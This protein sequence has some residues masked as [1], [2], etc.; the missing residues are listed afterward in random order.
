[1]LMSI[2]L[3]KPAILV[4]NYT[5]VTSLPLGTSVQVVQPFWSAYIESIV[6]SIVI[7]YL[8]VHDK[9][10]GLFLVIPSGRI[11]H[12]KQYWG[13]YSSKLYIIHRMHSVNA[14][15]YLAVISLF[16]MTGRDGAV[17]VNSSS[18][19]MGRVYFVPYAPESDVKKSAP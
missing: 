6:R 16:V 12:R 7:T 19:M 10:D 11:K 9:L 3:Y 8:L 14:Y 15:L 13:V 18:S 17:L 1:M 5:A 4:C 2:P